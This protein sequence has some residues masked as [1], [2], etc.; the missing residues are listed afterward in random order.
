MFAEMYIALLQ[1]KIQVIIRR[2]INLFIYFTGI[3]FILNKLFEKNGVYILFYHRL[4]DATKQKRVAASAV[5][6]QSFDEQMDFLSKNYKIISMDEVPSVLKSSSKLPEKYMVITFDD[7]YRDNLIYGSDIFSKYNLRPTIYLTA[8]CI[9]NQ[10]LMWFDIV[11]DIVFSSKKSVITLKVGQNTI[12]KNIDSYCSKNALL[13]ILKSYMKSISTEDKLKYIDYMMSEFDLSIDTKTDLMLTW[14]Q[15]LE[16]IS[17][18]VV[19]GSH[20]MTHPI[21][22]RSKLQDA[23]YEISESKRIIEEKLNEKII[24]FS[25][26]NGCKSDFNDEIKK[27][28]SSNY[29]TGVT[30]I[31]GINK[32]SC[33]MYEL[34]RIYVGSDMNI[35]DFKI[36]LLKVKIVEHFKK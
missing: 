3:Y 16:L 24:H 31:T 8:N 25:Y 36:H 13:K 26:P 15:S 2:L 4:S 30:T 34:K 12:T 9:E 17:Q 1:E 20:T 19:I 33:D 29:A 27:I 11:N 35:I 32:P 7:G 18:K 22:T 21:L 5:N 6:Y 28:V 23:E 14:K 10:T